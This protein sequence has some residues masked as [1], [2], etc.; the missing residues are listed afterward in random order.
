[1][2]FFHLF[3]LLS[4]FSTAFAQQRSVKT[5]NVEP[6]SPNNGMKISLY[7]TNLH[8]NQRKNGISLIPLKIKAPAALQ[9]STTL[10]QAAIDGINRLFDKAGTNCNGGNCCIPRNLNPHTISLNGI[11]GQGENI[12]NSDTLNPFSNSVQP[13]ADAVA[14]AVGS[15]ASERSKWFTKPHPSTFQSGSYAAGHYTQMIN[16]KTTQL[17]C[18]IGKNKQNGDKGC[19][20]VLCRY[21]APDYQVNRMVVGY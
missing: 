15:W 8:N 3:A 2:S 4:L 14:K 11:T 18:A 10:Q 19:Q 17:G 1:M 7:V 12:W 5:L 16:Q 13:F 6:V 21:A 20:I 9:Y